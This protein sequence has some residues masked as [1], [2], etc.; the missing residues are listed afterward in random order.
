MAKHEKTLL[1]VLRGTSDA[2]IRFG[3]LTSLLESLGFQCRTKRSHHIFF[4][5]GVV[6]NP[7]SSA[8]EWSG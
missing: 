8:E 6:E 3:E 1:S 7:E 4:K 2:N 5:E